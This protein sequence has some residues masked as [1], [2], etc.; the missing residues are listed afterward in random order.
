MHS[1]ILITGSQRS[2]TTLLSLI[3]DS[4]PALTTI[5]EVDFVDARL[6]HYL[7]G[8]S[9]A[10]LKLPNRAAELAW[11]R[12]LPSPHVLWC[13][14]DPRDVVASMVTFRPEMSRTA[15]IVWALHPQ[16]APYE[17][18]L[19]RALLDETPFA[20]E[21]ATYDAI[22]RKPLLDCTFGEAVFAG[23][24]CWRLKNE[25]LRVYERE[26]IGYRI[27]EYETL[28]REPRVAVGAILEDVGVQWHDDVLRHHELHSGI[29]IAETDFA[30]AIDTASIGKWKRLFTD[31]EVAVV[32]RLTRALAERFGC[33]RD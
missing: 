8:P 3:L 33:W 11:I 14:R 26:G 31:A 22:R 9:R 24:L 13:V 25:V 27:V 20:D 4:H 15:S 18:A 28:V 5:D 23:A 1:P 29:Y 16:G 7:G 12:A 6:P 30:R 32:A 17:I 10:V 19:A 21:L 2:G